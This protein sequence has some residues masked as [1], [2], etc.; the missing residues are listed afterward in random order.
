MNAENLPSENVEQAKIS[1][2]NQIDISDNQYNVDFENQQEETC[3]SEE[4]E[5]H[6]ETR[7]V[8]E[9]VV[10]MEKLVNLDNAG[11]ESKAFNALKN[12]ALAKIAEETEDRK[13]EHAENGNT[14]EFRWEHPLLSKVSGL[15]NIFREK[16]D[17]FI[18]NR[19][20]EH[21]ENL[22]ER[23]NIIEKLK[24]LYTNTEPG[25]NLFKAIR[26]IKQLWANAGKVAKSEFKML[27]NNYFYHLNQFYAMLD[28]NKEFLEQEYAHNLEKRQ[29]I[30]SR[31]KELQ[32]EPAIQKVLNELQYLHKLWKEEAEPVAEEFR[33]STW[34]EFKEVSNKIHER[35]AEFSANL[36]AVQLA[37]LEK[38]NAIIE[39]I[40]KLTVPAVEASH[41]HWQ[42]AIKK[43]EAL[44]EEF[45][46]LGGVPRKL[47]N[48]NW[49]DFK[50][51]LR[52]FNTTKND[53]YKGLKDNQITNLER[54]EQLIQ[55]AKDNM[56]SEDWDTA[57]PLFKK[58]QDEWKNIGHVPRSQAN[59]IWDEFR[60]ACNAFFDNYRVKTNTVSDNWKENYKQ[61]KA[62]LE[63]LKAITN[64]E[65]S[66]E[67]IEAIKSQWNAIG[68]VPK[69]K[70]S[71]NSEFNRTLKDKLKINQVT[72]FDLKDENL[73]QSQI[74]DKARKLK[75]QIADLEAEISTLE[76]NLGFFKNP[77][78]ENPLLR[79][80]F[81]KIDEKKAQVEGL[82]QVFHQM[83]AGE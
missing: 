6:E 38:K 24:N 45:I 68:K 17:V 51:T 25:T 70:I 36:E 18:K 76:N 43:V 15:S 65:G 60:D 64:E 41:S 29:H 61:K 79:D 48:Q 8:E 80:I 3:F 32:N 71:I 77:S 66:V 37:N 1:E 56:A 54:K 33:E 69:E 30:I 67:K 73:S 7:S 40:K 49:L 12:S 81:S 46:K 50:Q 14:E 5:M 52:V 82:K 55:T 53:F 78:R 16:Y 42:K 63:Q 44:R 22:E 9:L 35:K 27:N 20:K 57:V 13:Y 83:I 11:E 34:E 59:R 72:E 2:Q 19:E 21:A 39:E 26:E 23:K 28:L 31:A 47:S 10:E 75:N 62:L 58:L 74:A 4:I